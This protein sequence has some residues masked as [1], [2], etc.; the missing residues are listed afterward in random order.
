MPIL[1]GSWCFFL[2]VLVVFGYYLWLFVFLVGSWLFLGV[3]GGFWKSL[4]DFGG[5]WQFSVVLV[6]S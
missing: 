6:G 1:G 3:L 4:V 2:V 5:S